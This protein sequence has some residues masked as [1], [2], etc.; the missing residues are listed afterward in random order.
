MCLRPLLFDNR[1][2]KTDKTVLILNKKKK[3]NITG[4]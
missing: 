2:K 1:N 4:S 3:Q